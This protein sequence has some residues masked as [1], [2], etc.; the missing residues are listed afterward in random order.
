[1]LVGPLVVAA[2]GI[3]ALVRCVLSLVNA[4]KRL[5]MPA[6]ETWKV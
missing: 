2:V 3:W 4:Q 5:A 6:P 1:V